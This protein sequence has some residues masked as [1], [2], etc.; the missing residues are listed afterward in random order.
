MAEKF[1][2]FHTV[3]RFL[4]AEIFLQSHLFMKL[5][6]LV[7]L[8]GHFDEVDVFLLDKPHENVLFK[9]N[10]KNVIL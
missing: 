10:L 3:L 7:A 1:L 5:P 8:I 4:S 9:D 6:K 2:N